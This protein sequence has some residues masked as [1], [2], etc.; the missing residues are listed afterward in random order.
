MKLI[1][2]LGN[3]GP[4]Y[5]ATRH[6]IGFRVVEALAARHGIDLVERRRLRGRAGRGRI[7]GE[8]VL[9]LEPLTFMNASGASVREALR[10][11]GTE[12]SSLVVVHDDVDLDLGT[13]RVKLGG[14]DG[15]HKG[16]RSIIQE[17]GEDGFVRIRLGIGRP[18]LDGGVVGHVLSGFGE[19]EREIIEEAVG[20]GV[21]ASEAVLAEGPVVAMNRYNRRRPGKRR[22]E[23]PGDEHGTGPR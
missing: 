15:G 4:E 9:L 5:R 20:R 13:V 22:G 16:V 21:E 3:P 14:G 10:T 17:T 18:G 11:T 2:G 23:S 19:G 7:S 12:A 8:S 6:N 1:A